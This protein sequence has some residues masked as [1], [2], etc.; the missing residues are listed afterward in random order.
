M[1]ETFIK[2]DSVIKQTIYFD[3]DAGVLELV[4]THNDFDSTYVLDYYLIGEEREI[5]LLGHKIP[6]NVE[7]SQ[8]YL[9]SATYFNYLAFIDTEFTNP[10][11]L[12][13]VSDLGGR[14]KL[15]VEQRI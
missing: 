6:I 8:T 7:N 3:Y 9:E 1:T 4:I 11:P 5:I 15:L 2:L 13:L 10:E 12:D 14:I